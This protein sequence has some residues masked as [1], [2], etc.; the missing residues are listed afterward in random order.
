[1]F[2]IF[3]NYGLGMSFSQFYQNYE[4]LSFCNA[5]L[6]NKFICQ[7]FGKWFKLV[8]QL[9]GGIFLFGDDEM[10]FL[11]TTDVVQS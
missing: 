8:Q 7:K 5:S 9:G 6:V 2:L 4:I 1:M 11:I 10:N 3:P